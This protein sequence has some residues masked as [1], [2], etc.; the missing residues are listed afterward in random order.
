MDFKEFTDELLK[1]VTGMAGDIF[2]AGIAKNLKNNGVERTAITA[3][4][5]QWRGSPNIYLEGFYEEYKSG[6]RGIGGIAGEVYRQ[7]MEHMDDL[8]GVRL[9]GLRKWDEARPRI[10]AKLINFENN[11]ELLKW[12]PYRKFLDLAAVYYVQ[13]E[14]FKDGGTGAFL[15]NDSH[16]SVW[17]QTEESLYSAAVQNMRLLGEPVFESMEEILGQMMP[18]FQLPLPASAPAARM[19]VLTN[20]K[21]IFGA[22]E[23]LDNGTLR[24]VSDELGGDFIVLPSSLHEC[25]ILPADGTLSYQK[26]ADMV[27]GVNI[28]AV[29]IEERLSDHVYLYGRE[30]GALRIAA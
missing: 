29:S 12:K 15:V 25:I 22:A 17:G 4:A 16:M 19:Y 14:G 26:L 23:L 5:P 20:Q 30:E 11:I 1:E 3:T 10:Y 21:K 13:V 8:K 18:E 27:A 28:N 9:D 2:R 24:Q 7:L 6:D